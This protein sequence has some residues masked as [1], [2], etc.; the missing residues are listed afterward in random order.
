MIFFVFRTIKVTMSLLNNEKY[1][2]NAL[3][4]LKITKQLLI[5]AQTETRT[6]IWGFEPVNID[7]M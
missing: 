1:K 5:A 2:D 4:F 6:G 3:P 7:I